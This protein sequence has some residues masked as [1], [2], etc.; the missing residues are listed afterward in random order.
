MKSYFCLLILLCNFVCE[1]QSRED[2]I[3]DAVNQILVDLEGPGWIEEGSLSYNYLLSEPPE[4]IAF[5]MKNIEK[6]FENASLSKYFSPADKAGFIGQNLKYDNFSYEQSKINNKIVL[7]LTELEKINDATTPENFWS[8]FE[9][10]F[11]RTGLYVI[12]FPL[13]SKDEKSMLVCV[14]SQSFGSETS[15]WVYIYTKK[16]EEWKPWKVVLFSM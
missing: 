11:G 7:S 4:Y 12:S 13:F 5:D 8:T 16:G 1:A 14:E 10:K 3:Y 15:A 2:K 6:L 9:K